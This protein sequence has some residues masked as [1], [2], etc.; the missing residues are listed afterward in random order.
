[1]PQRLGTAALPHAV[2][3][4]SVQPALF[5]PLLKSGPD[6]L[7]VKWD[8]VRQDSNLCRTK[9]PAA[10]P[11][12]PGE[13]RALPRLSPSCGAFTPQRA[14]PRQRGTKG[15]RGGTKEGAASTK[16]LSG[17]L[18]LARHKELGEGA[19]RLTRIFLEG[20]A[21]CQ[22]GGRAPH[23]QHWPPAGRSLSRLSPGLPPGTG[24]LPPALA[25]PSRHPWHL[26]R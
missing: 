11:H 17:M 2:R 1:M 15:G 7:H 4:S 8:A 9:L 13:S 24:G 14:V 10:V 19:D 26:R 12:G 6:S 3:G 5:W 21:H 20:G 16:A 18:T 23:T 22:T 25:Q